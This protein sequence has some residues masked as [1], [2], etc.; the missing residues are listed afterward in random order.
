MAKLA[1]VCEGAVLA[2]MLALGTAAGG[3]ADGFELRDYLNRTWRNECVRFRLNDAQWKHAQAGHALVAP[4]GRPTPYQVLPGANAGERAIEFP[5]DL[6]AFETRSFRFTT[7]QA[8][9]TTDLAIEETDAAVKL[10]NKLTGIALSKTLKGGGPIQQ[11]RLNSGKWVGSSSLTS[12]QEVTSYAVEVT[13]RGPVFAEAVCRVGWGEQSRWELRVRLNANEPVVLVDENCAYPGKAAAFALSLSEGFA[14]EE[15]LFR[16]GRNAI[17]KNATW[18]IEPGEVFFLE[19]WLR[20]WERDRQGACFGVYNR[21]DPDLLAVAARQAGAWVDPQIGQEKQGR[22]QVPVTRTDKGLQ[23]TFALRNAGRKWMICAL[24]KDECL[25]VLQEKDACKSPLPYQYLIKHGHFP[26]NAVKDYVL[27]WQGDHENHP[28]LFV[29]KADLAKRDKGDAAKHERAIAGYLRDPNPLNQFTMDGPLNAYYATGNA[30]LARYLAKNAARSLQECVDALVKQD[31]IPLGSAP[32][33]LSAIPASIAMADAIMAS[34][35]TAP[36]ARERLLGQVAFLGYTL[37]RPDYWSP[38]RGYAANPNMTTSVRGYLATVA[39][40]IPSHPLAAAWAKDAMAE[41]KNQLDNWADSNGGWLEAPHYAM[42]SYDQILGAFLMAHNAGFNEYL[43]EPKM[44][45]VMQWFGKISTPPDSR[46][47]GSRHLPCIGNTYLNEP[48][49]EFG[50]LAYLWREKDPAFAAQMQWLHRQYKSYSYPGIGGAYP[51]L[52]GYRSILQDASIPEQ[53]PAWKSELFPETGVILRNTFPCDR[54]T[55]LHLIAGRNHAH[56]DD[57]S[58]SITVWGK[59]RILADDFG[60]YGCAPPD[61]H[62]LLD[63]PVARGT[64]QV[65][66]FV[67]AERCDYVL[68]V[69]Q[70]QTRQVL[71]VKDADPAKPNYFVIADTLAAA[72]PFT[73]R[74]WCTAAK[75]TPAGRLATVS[76]KEDVDMEV[77]FVSPAQVEPKTEERTRTSGSGMNAEGRWGPMATMQTGLLVTCPQEKTLTAVLYPRMKAEAAASFT[78]LADG[79]GVMVKSGAGTDYVFLS[80]TPFSFAEGPV[81]FSGT[82]G[83][84]QLREGKPVLC[85]PAEGTLEAQGERLQREGTAA[86]AAK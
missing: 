29:K 48:T 58:G 85:L 3:E 73:W 19:P 30:E 15:L 54:E 66:T 61:D 32:H 26:L 7:D 59:G 12:D 35:E 51:A 62:S 9:P 44:K 63:S 34:A 81:K 6:N 2:L 39:C 60:Y 5:A 77:Y 65:R 55:Q 10:S 42:V 24:Q 67:P 1:A 69:K 74:L 68:G 27:R 50:T 16:Y 80:T 31:G 75:V 70:A 82:V 18:K 43:Y 4:D 38:E 84:A 78:P 83:V 45:S 37:S 79:K 46:L 20:W 14:A 8:K 22:P 53:A 71:F 57:D 13:A 36:E 52:A 86:P 11:I 47:G 33:H 23:L 28:R 72:A 76:G 41:L 40:C 21:Q 49:G 64:M 56:Y 17:G 25:A